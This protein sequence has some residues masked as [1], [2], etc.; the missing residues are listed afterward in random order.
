MAY[1][2]GTSSSIKDKMFRF[3]TAPNDCLVKTSDHHDSIVE[4]GV[5]QLTSSIAS[6]LWL[7]LQKTITS[8]STLQAFVISG[9]KT[10]ARSDSDDMLEEVRQR[11]K[12]RHTIGLGDEDDGDFDLLDDESLLH[13]TL[14]STAEIEEDLL[15]ESAVDSSGIETEDN[16]SL[17]AVHLGIKS[18]DTLFRNNNPASIYAKSSQ[19]RTNNSTL[20][21]L[22]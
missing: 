7:H 13:E 6:R 9:S 11:Q 2:R 16:L 19:V 12:H 22:Q 14:Y 3:T 21:K 15:K 10:A 17:D 18:P 5:G 20:A 8:K 1:V 4:Q